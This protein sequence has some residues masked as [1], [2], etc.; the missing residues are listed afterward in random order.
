VW[1]LEAERTNFVKI[2][3]DKE[4]WDKEADNFV[5][6]YGSL[7]PVRVVDEI[8]VLERL[9]VSVK[10]GYDPDQE[11]PK[12]VVVRVYA[13]RRPAKPEHVATLYE[14][15]LVDAGISH[16][17]QRTGHMGFDYYG[18]NLI[19]MIRHGELVTRLN[20][21]RLGWR[22]DRSPFPHPRLVQEFYRML[23]GA[24]SGEGLVQHLTTRTR[25][26]VPAAINLVPACVAFYLREYGK[27]ESRKEIHRLLNEHVL[28]ETSK[29]LPDETYGSSA[30]NQLWRDVSNHAKVRDPLRDAAHWLY[31]EG[32]D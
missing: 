17:E 1:H 30:T 8:L 9:P 19:L 5:R 26:G 6:R 10:V 20:S 31:W 12:E 21:P 27:I 22:I 25:G 4:A 11:N 13:H 24:P 32:D 18:P 28:C 16:D 15:T 7:R 29:T 2:E 14:K 3:E 23:L